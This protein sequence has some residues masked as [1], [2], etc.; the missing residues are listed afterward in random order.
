LKT[1]TLVLSFLACGLATA[2]IWTCQ[3]LPAASVRLELE[4]TAEAVLFVASNTSTSARDLLPAA[5]AEAGTAP[6]H[7]PGSTWLTVFRFDN[8]IREVFCRPLPASSE[9]LLDELVP[10]LAP[11]SGQD[12]TYLDQAL[13]TVTARIQACQGRCVLVLHHDGHTEGMA[14]A[15]H[16]IVRACASR[17]ARHPRL[18]AVFVVGV[19]PSQMAEVRR[20]FA[21]VTPKLRFVPAGGLD[22]A[23]IAELLRSGGQP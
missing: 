3:R 11:L 7:L 13:E 20:D 22:Y 14:P 16:D 6:L 8:R 10:H 4:Q 17:L 21:P 15:G 9:A 19:E 1:P 12:N 5:V 2:L 23:L 18:V